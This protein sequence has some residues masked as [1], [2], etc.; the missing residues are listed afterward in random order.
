MSFIR[1]L[2][3]H[4]KT[5]EFS[6]KLSCLSTF[7]NFKGIMHSIF[8]DITPQDQQDALDAAFEE[9]ARFKD[10]HCPYDID[11]EKEKK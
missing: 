10:G 1:G 7:E 3:I 9:C 11:L 4:K 2:K 6:C 8:E 5:D